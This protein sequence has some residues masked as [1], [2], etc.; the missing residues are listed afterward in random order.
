MELLN[1]VS[2]EN[3]FDGRADLLLLGG[4]TR[5]MQA[6]VQG[7]GDLPKFIQVGANQPGSYPPSGGPCQVG[8]NQPRVIIPF[9]MVPAGWVPVCPGSSPFRWSLPRCQV[10]T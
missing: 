2:L 5:G 10:D 4:S 3:G 8:A 1:F 6:A 9:Q 7:P